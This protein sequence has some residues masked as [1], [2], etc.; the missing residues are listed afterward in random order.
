MN[1]E[2]RSKTQL[3]L[4]ST[5]T[6]D[7]AGV[8]RSREAEGKSNRLDEKET[9]AQRESTPLAELLNQCEQSAAAV[10]QPVVRINP[11]P[12]V[13]SPY[14]GGDRWPWTAQQENSRTEG[15]VDAGSRS[16]G[17]PSYEPVPDL[18]PELRELDYGMAIEE[19]PYLPGETYLSTDA[20]GRK[21]ARVEADVGSIKTDG[22]NYEYEY[23]YE[24]AIGGTDDLDAPVE[25][26]NAALDPDDLLLSASFVGGQHVFGDWYEDVQDEEQVPADFW[27]PNKL[28]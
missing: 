19:D 27:R 21:E 3:H 28:Y 9:A 1:D 11:S 13:A 20:D 18:Y 5:T 14:Y 7:F 26:E 6:G 10:Q 24:T 15:P 16:L 23:E 2:S 22:L 12:A 8:E 25:N 17:F 4:R